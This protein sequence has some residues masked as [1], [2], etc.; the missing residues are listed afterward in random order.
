MSTME[1]PSSRAGG[2]GGERART[3]RTSHNAPRRRRR[4]AG[5]R[6]A[7]TVG[8][9]LGTLLLIMIVTGCFLA[10]YGVVYLNTVIIPNA[11]PNLNLNLNESSTIYYIDQ[12]TQEAVELAT[13]Y[14]SENRVILEYKEIPD[15]F[16]K[17]AVA[18][19]DKRFYQHKGVDWVRTA[20]A[21]FYM[22]TG[23]DIQGGSTIT[24]Q[25]IKN[26]SGDNEVTVKRKITEIFKALELEKE[27]SKDDIITM[28]LNYIYLG[29]R[30]YGIATASEYYFGKDVSEITLAEAASI[31]AI[32]N[33]PSIYGPN[34]TVV[35]ENSDG[36]LWDAKQWNKYRQELILNAMLEQG[37]I[38]QEEHDEAVAQELVFT[39]GQTQSTEEEQT[40]T[41]TNINSWYVD[42]VIAEVVNYYQETYGLNTEAANQMVYGGGLKIYTPFDPDV[43]EAVDEIYTNRENLDYTSSDGQQMQSGIT[44][45]DNE[46]GYV[47]AMAG[48]I[49][50]KTGNRLWN[51]ATDS[52]RQPGSSIKPLAAYSPAIEMGLVTPYTVIDD[53]PYQ[54]LDGTAWPRN[55]NRE[56]HGLTTV[57]NGITHSTN[58]IAVKLVGDYVTPEAS[59]QFLQERYGITTL[60]DDVEVNG[61]VMT[62][63]ALAPLALGGLTN[64]LSPYEMTAAYATFPRNGAYTEPTVVLRVE[65]NDGELVWDNTPETTYPIKESTAYYMNVL[66]DAASR[67]TGNA[68]RNQMGGRTMA[69]K[70]GTTTDNYDRW[71]AGYTPY[72]TAVVWTGYETPAYIRASINPAA[73][74]WGQVMFRI[75]EKLELEDRSFTSDVSL[76]SVSICL[77]CG[78]RATD[79]CANDIRGNRTMTASFV[80]GT[81]PTAYCTCHVP[82]TV[83]TEDPILNWQGEVVANAYHYATEYCPEESVRE[84]YIVDYTRDEAASSVMVDDIYYMKYFYDG[85]TEP[86]C[87]VHTE[88]TV[89]PENPE[90]TDPNQPPE[91]TLPGE[92]PGNPD[93][94]NDDPAAT[95]SADPS[96]EPSTQPSEQPSETPPSDVEFI[97]AIQ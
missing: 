47:V 92:D 68:A 38:T 1:R 5:V 29:S 40:T 41:A 71:F 62:D 50:E 46:T 30:Q 78:L 76:T 19:E 49:G 42:E 84:V 26:Y 74:L 15:V 33:N 82:I 13:C 63:K 59:F 60:V 95:P 44:V 96:A 25:V 37:M 70:T 10:C 83:C 17:A 69:G 27:Y 58:T 32:T 65:T 85:L 48:A 45:V 43:Q 35:M 53:S 22:F 64:G 75:Y 73:K 79:A 24:Q 20:A 7:A 18:I 9:V 89:D 67:G 52:V 36:E 2:E 66:L 11:S 91:E 3:P 12:E 87:S 80:E 34:S 88:A 54:I 86:Y 6:V 81:Q 94:G 97:P 56:Y 39:M 28:Y 55:D 77:D 57:L 14:G 93:S 21:V 31:I 23:Q 8:K 16:I 72:Y 61:R 4:S 90:G 51:F